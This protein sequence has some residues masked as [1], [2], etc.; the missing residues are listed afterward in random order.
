MTF[1]VVYEE[2]CQV[3]F[4]PSGLVFGESD[5]FHER[6]IRAIGVEKCF[7]NSAK[8]DEIQGCAPE[9]QERFKI[10]GL[11]REPCEIGDPAAARVHREL[12]DAVKLT[13]HDRAIG[14]QIGPEGNLTTLAERLLFLFCF[15][16]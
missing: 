16:G 10:V 12:T 4:P 2:I 5:R 14:E 8:V 13:V 11:F 15:N 9:D 7:V 3:D 1:T 6:F